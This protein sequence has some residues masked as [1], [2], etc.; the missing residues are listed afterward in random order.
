MN[1]DQALAAFAALSDPTRLRILRF[2]VTKGP[3][4]AAAGAIGEG[5]GAA[6]SR[7]SF[8]LSALTQAGLCRR[9]KVSRQVVYRV[10]FAA[11]AGLMAFMIEDC[12]QSHPDLRHCCAALGLAAKG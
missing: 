12:C 5:L 10:D 11:L 9:E 1:E 3:T 7:A 8:H 6:P 4:G 2:L